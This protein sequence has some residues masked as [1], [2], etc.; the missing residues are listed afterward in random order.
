MFHY[1]DMFLI[2][3]DALKR[4]QWMYDPDLRS[5]R[6][7]HGCSRAWLAQALGSTVDLVTQWEEGV[8]LPS[9]ALQAAL[10]RILGGADQSCKQ[11]VEV[12]AAPSPQDDVCAFLL[13]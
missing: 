7:R 3:G 1:G 10:D 5:R 2:A 12:P 9:S 4:R 13:L 8:S 11:V 6:E